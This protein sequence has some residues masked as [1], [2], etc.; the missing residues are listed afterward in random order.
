MPKN[1]E[2]IVKEDILLPDGKIFEAHY[3]AVSKKMERF[4]IK[5][6]DGKLL[7]FTEFKNIDFITPEMVKQSFFNKGIAL[8]KEE[9]ERITRKLIKRELDVAIDFIDENKGN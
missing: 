8:K 3:N 5:D 7:E 9:I 4:F 1:K 6:T 2:E